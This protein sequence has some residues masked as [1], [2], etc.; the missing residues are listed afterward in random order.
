MRINITSKLVTCLIFLFS[1]VSIGTTLYSYHLVSHRRESQKILIRAIRATNE[2]ITGSDTLTTAARAYAATGVERYRRDF[3]TELTVVRSRDHA[4]DELRRLGLT[5]AEMHRLTQ[6]KRNSD[7]LVS[8]ENEAF[9]AAGAGDLRNAVALVYGDEY[10]RSKESIIEPIRQARSNIETRF[11]GQAARLSKEADVVET[12]A[13]VTHLLNVATILGVLLI[14]FQRGVITPVVTLTDKTK[15]LVAGDR[16]VR[17]GHEND[18]SEIGELARTLEGYRQTVDEIERQRWIKN[19]LTDIG[20]AL[21][22]AETPV[23]FAGRLLSHLAPMLRCGA[24]LFS[25]RD[26]STGRIDPVGGYGLGEELRSR[27][28]FASGEGF[29]GEAVREGKPVVIRDIPADYFHIASGMGERP[30]NVV[31]VAPIINDGR[32]LA[33]IELAS[34]VPLDD[35]QWSLVNELSRIVAPRLEILLNVI[36]TKRLLEATQQQASI[37]EAQAADLEQKAGELHAVNVEQRAIFD[38]ASMGIVFIKDRVILRC[39][40][41]LETLFGYAPGELI[42]AT[43]RAWYEDDATYAEVGREVADSLTE[44]GVHE[45]ERQLV[46]K[47]GSRF[48][49][50]MTAQAIDPTDLSKGLVGMLD[51]ITDERRAAEALRT[52]MDEQSAI[53]HT[54]DTGIVLACNRIFRRCNHRVEEMFGYGPGELDGQST[55][56]IYKDDVVY[57]Q[58]GEETYPQIRRGETHRREEQL[59][60]KD[61]S[62]VW[63]RM[64]A[65]AVDPEDQAKGSVWILVMSP[66]C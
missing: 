31:T 4:M 55:R 66:C 62:L 29:V 12:V 30:P 45:K 28:R 19:G 36:R 1:C 23:D 61:G 48:W 52:A 54:A 49:S 39:N 5:E 18:R 51:D 64:T 34:F 16:N 60:R 2:L 59:K 42:G 65:H 57:N 41:R 14:F 21:Q 35:Q 13:I 3:Q 7:A 27:R 37:L 32:V 40:R 50:R 33:L 56:I 20:N 22:R 43:T 63:V 26:E 47:D 25:L 24:A 6:A 46:R 8:L 38:S 9:R 17:F 10:L 11:A 58:V 15:R 44:H 53:F